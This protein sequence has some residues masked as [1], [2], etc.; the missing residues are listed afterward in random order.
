MLDNIR[1]LDLTMHLSGPY[2][3]W[4]LGSL[5]AD[6][7]KVE[8]P[9]GGD[10]VREV[11]PFVYGQSTYFGSVN[12]NK[13]GVVIDL[14]SGEGKSALAELIK[15]SD[16]LVENF[17]PGVLA[18]LG[19]AEAALKALNPDLIYASITGF[20]QHGAMKKRPAFDIVIQ[21]MSG[22]MSMTGPA[23]GPPTAVGVSI[24]DL[25][26]GIFTALDVVAALFQRHR[27][28]ISRRIDISMLDCQMAL[29]E[30]AV[31]RYLN[32]GEIPSRVGS[33]HPKITPFQSYT[34]KDGIIVVA[35][36]GEPN[37][38]RMCDAMGLGTTAADPRFRDN[39]SRVRHYGELENILIDIFKTKSSEEWIAL[40]VAAEV[41]CGPVN[42]LPKA[43]T[44]EQVQE[45]QMI[46][47]VQLSGGETLDFAASPIG[48]RGGR[49]E[50]PAPSLGQHT[51]EVLAEIRMSQM[52]SEEI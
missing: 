38:K 47:R 43:L 6:V 24:A 10:P 40:L 13:R 18:K 17:R 19:F 15:K 28:G 25:S 32:A 7:I 30:N 39:E 22:L 33:R 46:S 8:R 21:G 52:L 11:G 27:T 9:D 14:K 1:V 12:R 23:D 20:G 26:A 35:A 37:W 41:P 48:V 3:C 31:A 50:R 44:M 49:Q 34:T 29:L 5:G 36:D 2:C 4:L 16:V 42:T 45:R 51:N